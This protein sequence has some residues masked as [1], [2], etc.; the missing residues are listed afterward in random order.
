MSGFHCFAQGIDQGLNAGV[1]HFHGSLVNHQTRAD[2]G[3]EVLGFQAIGAQGVTGI[4]HVDD[5]VGQTDQRCQLHR[6]VQFDDVDLTALFI[7]LRTGRL[8]PVRFAPG[9]RR[10]PGHAAR[11]TAEDEALSRLAERLAEGDITPEEYLERSS[12]LRGSGS[13]TSSTGTE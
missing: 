3:N 10:G 8:G 2:G 12:V 11:P 9:G 6:A 5:F 7:L 1:L 13:G 4:D